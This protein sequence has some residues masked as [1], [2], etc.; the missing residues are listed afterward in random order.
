MVGPQVGHTD[1]SLCQRCGEEEEMPDYIV[2][3]C[4][5]IRRV[6]DE[7]DRREWAREV[8][9]QWDNWDALAS[10]KWIKMEDTGRVD[11]EGR[12]VEWI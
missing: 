2:F 6:K 8:G 3:R 1:D 9:V 4:R 12:V 10:K 11:D 7:R 5:I